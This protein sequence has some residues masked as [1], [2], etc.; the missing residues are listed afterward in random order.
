MR[1]ESVRQRVAEWIEPGY[2]HRLEERAVEILRNEILDLGRESHHTDPLKESFNQQRDHNAPTRSL[3][4]P[5]SLQY[6]NWILYNL[7]TVITNVVDTWTALTVGSGMTIDIPEGARR[8]DG[9]DAQAA[10]DEFDDKVGFSGKGQLAHQMF[11]DK[12]LFGEVFPWFKGRM[13]LNAMGD[14]AMDEKG[15]P[16][17]EPF[18][19]DMRVLDPI[20]QGGIEDIKHKPGD[21]R[22]ITAYKRRGVLGQ[23]QFIPPSQIVH[24]KLRGGGDL[25]HG[26]PVCKEKVIVKVKQLD[27]TEDTLWR[28]QEFLIRILALRYKRG[29]NAADS[30]L[31]FSRPNG[32]TLLEIPPDGEVEEP[33]LRKLVMGDRLDNSPDQILLGSI[34]RAV[35][36]PRHLVAQ[37]YREGN[38]ASLLTAE[39]PTA[40]LAE[41]RVAQGEQDVKAV[42]RKVIGDRQPNGEPLEVGVNIHPVVVA[43]QEEEWKFWHQAW[44]DGGIDDITYWGKLGLDP[45]E[46]A[47]R[48]EEQLARV[49]KIQESYHPENVRASAASWEAIERLASN[50]NL[51]PEILPANVRAV[52]EAIQGGMHGR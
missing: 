12:Y 52:V 32:L 18:A 34:A 51:D 44:S 11:R 45:D 25:L 47:A 50:E 39:G 5:Y 49:Q 29:S 42:V 41:E 10:W 2:R 13:E 24:W 38:R 36:L 8:E 37:D 17:M 26:R 22:I 14:P 48:K 43:D 7:G 28:L 3:L 46:I 4:T 9:V 1:F 40:K 33:D 30:A 27:Q 20:S 21:T 6:E 15:N 31:T 16:Q 23:E 19:I 35:V